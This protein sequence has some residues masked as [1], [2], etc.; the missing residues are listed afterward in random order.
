[1]L[2]SVIGDVKLSRARTIII[3]YVVLALAVATL[4]RLAAL[5]ISSVEDKVIV[6]YSQVDTPYSYDACYNGAKFVLGAGSCRQGTF[7]EFLSVVAAM[8]YAKDYHARGVEVAIDWWDTYFHQ[9]WAGPGR[10]AHFNWYVGRAGKYTSFS[11]YYFDYDFPCPTARPPLAQAR[12]L[13]Q[14][15]RLRDGI[16]AEIDAYVSRHFAGKHVIGVHYRGTDKI[17]NGGQ[18][19]VQIYVDAVRA[20]QRDNSWVYLASD[21]ADVVNVFEAEFPGRVLSQNIRRAQSYS[22]TGLH[23]SGLGTVHSAMTDMLRLS[24]CNFLIK[25]RSSL[26]DVSLLISSGLQHMFV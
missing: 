20:V 3:K 19:P 16:A 10:R 13:V 12:A 2:P 23:R 6:V 21:T 26:S 4:C 14:G 25:G 18:R 7:S 1:M 8:A 5:Q 24:R 11:N 22:T 17:V 9:P 15:L